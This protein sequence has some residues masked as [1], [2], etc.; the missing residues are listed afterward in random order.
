ML[1]TGV[2]P[3]AAGLAGL[4][5]TSALSLCGLMNWMVRM[6]TELEVNMNS[7]ERVLEYTVCEPEA[8]AV[9]PGR[10]PLPGWP[11]R[12]AIEVEALVVRYRP[13]LDPVL[14]GISFSVRPREKVRG[15]VLCKGEFTPGSAGALLRCLHSAS[16]SAASL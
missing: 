2:Q 1:V 3:R 14:R 11:A 16:A 13:E 8:P 7:V 9:V 15:R 4:A 10:R 6:T 12:G 5:L